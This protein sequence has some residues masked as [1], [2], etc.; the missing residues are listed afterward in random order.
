VSI[1]ACEL[2]VKITYIRQ[3]KT[4]AVGTALD[5]P[6]TETGEFYEVEWILSQKVS[7]CSVN[8]VFNNISS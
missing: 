6:E 7:V 3:F 5:G 2:Y 4:H 1:S 8:V